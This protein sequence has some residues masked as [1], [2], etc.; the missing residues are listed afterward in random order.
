MH[1][2]YLAYPSIVTVHGEVLHNERHDNVLSDGDLLLCD[3]GAGRWIRT[4]DT[5]IL[6]PPDLQAKPLCD[7]VPCGPIET[8]R[9]PRRAR[10][11]GPRKRVGSLFRENARERS[12]GA[13]M[14]K[15]EFEHL[16]ADARVDPT[17]FRDA[18]SNIA[19]VVE[20]EPPREL[21]EEMEIEPPDTLLRLY[22][23]IPTERRW[24]AG[25]QLPDRIPISR[26]PRTCRQTR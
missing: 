6:R 21:L 15:A 1:S 24:D 10:A 25:N 23:G 4:S 9:N 8:A 19:I 7:R 26:A 22:Q 14:R 20:D 13:R 5:L 3:V 12:S 11:H 17:G 2:G 16:V 18:M